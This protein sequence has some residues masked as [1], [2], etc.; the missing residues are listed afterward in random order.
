MCL[1]K[2]KY[3]PPEMVLPLSASPDPL[4]PLLLHN[5][6]APKYLQIAPLNLQKIVSL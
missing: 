6:A 3:L 4:P 1:H 2:K 5:P